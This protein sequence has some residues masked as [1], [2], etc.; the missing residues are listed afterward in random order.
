MSDGWTDRKQRTLINFLV[1]GSKGTVFMESVDASSYMKT[2]EK[3]FELLDGFMERIGEQNVVQVI[4]D[5][6]ANFKLAGKMLMEKRK[7]Y[8]G[9]HVQRT[10]WI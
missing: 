7:I 9:H 6:G 5:N 4:T 1:N 10:A 2:G 8:F 3:V